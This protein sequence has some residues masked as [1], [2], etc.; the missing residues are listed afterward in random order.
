MK[1]EILIADDHPFMLE[2][3]KNVLQLHFPTSKIHTAENKRI[4]DT[5][6]SLTS[7]DILIQDVKFGTEDARLF[8]DEYL[9]K[10]PAMKIIVLSSVADSDS[11]Q[12]VLKMGVH[13]Y[14]IKSEATELLKNAIETI[15]QGKQFL[16]PEVSQI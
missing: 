15:F 4:L 8:L 2:G 11:I 6:L 5:I 7:V 10:Y 16:S 13:G 1:H 14:I 12:K 3:L 9:V